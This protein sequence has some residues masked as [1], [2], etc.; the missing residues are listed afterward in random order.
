MD[1]LKR[2]KDF[3]SGFSVFKIQKEKS[4]ELKKSLHR[5]I[6][7]IRETYNIYQVKKAHSIA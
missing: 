7:K 4:Y 6:G 3:I 2:E 1:L 5:S